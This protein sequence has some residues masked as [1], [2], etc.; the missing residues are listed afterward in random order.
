MGQL[1]VYVEMESGV[2]LGYSGD[3][4]WPSEH[5]IEEINPLVLDSTNGSPDCVR[6]FT[7]DEAQHRLVDLV[8]SRVKRGPMHI[9]GY[10]GTLQRG[11]QCLSESVDLPL[12]GSRS[13]CK[14][15][16]VYRRHGYAMRPPSGRE[17]G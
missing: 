13:L 17:D 14:Q 5:I 9:Q 11:I 4:Q 10:R 7:Q 16:E 3:F 8:C 12:V 6:F 15:V 1:R 2:R